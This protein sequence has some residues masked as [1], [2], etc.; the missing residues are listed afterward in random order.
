MYE[1][2]KRFK[3]SIK[4]RKELPGTDFKLEVGL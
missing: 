4:K 1:L 2:F 3:T